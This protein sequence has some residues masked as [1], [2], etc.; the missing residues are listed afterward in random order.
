MTHE[1]VD[2]VVNAVGIT[3][4]VVF[5]VTGIGCLNMGRSEGKKEAQRYHCQSLGYEDSRVTDR[6]TIECIKVTREV[7]R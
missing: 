6:G 1:E 2:R 3:A 5:V 4:L 7:A